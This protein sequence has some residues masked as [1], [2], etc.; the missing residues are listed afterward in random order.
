MEVSQAILHRRSIRTFLPDP[1]PAKVLFHLVELSR[2]YA[3]GANLQPVRYAVVTSAALRQSIFSQLKWAAYLPEFSPAPEQQPPA[4]I[5]LLRDCNVSRECR[6][7]LGAAA[8]NLMLAAQEQG[9]STCC[10][11]SFSPAQLTKLLGLAPQYVPELIL[12]VG[13]GAG[14]SHAVPMD[15][16]VQYR[17]DRHGELLV[18][19]LATDRVIVYSDQ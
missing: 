13:Y 7:E 9:L 12:A 16:S 2:L 6:F 10:L 4:Y 8:T 5:L 3:S 18:P 17:L 14:Q 19:K 1:V 15:Q 11:G